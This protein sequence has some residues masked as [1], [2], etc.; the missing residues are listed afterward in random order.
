MTPKQ[1][2]KIII[3][4][5]KDGKPGHEKQS[6]AFCNLLSQAASIKITDMTVNKNPLFYLLHALKS[7]FDRTIADEK[8]EILIGTGHRTHLPI[9]FYKF[10]LQA[11]AI[12]IMKPSLPHFLFDLIIA[13]QHDFDSN[14]KPNNVLLTPVPLADK[15]D[16]NSIDNKA[17]IL[18]GG[19][20][21][22]YHWHNDAVIEKI[23]TL[24]KAHNGM[25]WV[26]STSRRTPDHFIAQLKEEVAHDKNITIFDHDD[27][28]TDWL[29]DQLKASNEIWVTR[30]SASMLG[31]ALLTNARIGIIDLEP[32]DTNGKIEK[33]IRHLIKERYLSTD[34]KNTRKP[35]DFGPLVKSSLALLE[36]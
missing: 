34:T 1:K 33:M 9:L 21:K 2:Q 36:K 11:K 14:Q 20:S 3:W 28:A 30:D 18:I 26:V 6:I 29:S 32:K 5:F 12:I 15:I 35:I 8:P 24:I 25:Q 16:N 22:H 19:K 4:R 31:E 13:P 27:V 7:K 10:V 17:L 23:K